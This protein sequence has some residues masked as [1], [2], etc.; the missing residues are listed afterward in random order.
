[1]YK[2]Y[3]PILIGDTAELIKKDEYG[4]PILQYGYRPEFDNDEWL[5]WRQHGKDG[6]MEFQFGGSDTA[7]ILGISPWVSRHKLWSMKKGIKPAF[8][9][10]MNRDALE[11]GHDYEEGIRLNF[12]RKMEEEGHTVELWNDTNMYRSGNP[13][14]PFAI[15]DCDG[16]VLID[17][18][19]AILECKS[20][21]FDLTDKNRKVRN[22][23]LEN[24]A[25]MKYWKKGQVPPYYLCQVRHY[26]AVLNID[27]AYVICK[28]SFGVEP[29][30]IE[31]RRDLDEEEKLME[32][33][34]D[35]AQLIYNNIEPSDEETDG[36]T[37]KRWQDIFYPIPS[38]DE[39]ALPMEVQ[40][41]A[42][43]LE[44]LD[45]KISELE[46]KIK[47]YEKRKEKVVTEITPF[48]AEHE[49]GTLD[50]L[51]EYGKPYKR[52]ILKSETPYGRDSI[53]TVK[54]A[55]ELSSTFGPDMI[56]NIIFE[57]ASVTKSKLDSALKPYINEGIC[58][59]G[60]AAEMIKKAIIPG[61]AKPGRKFSYDSYEIDA[62]GFKIS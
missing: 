22:Q 19:P 61:K 48:L 29:A 49:R 10:D 44:Y 58:T 41:S 2:T 20:T 36:S 12:C 60:D 25:L 37:V 59:K 8:K 30:I 42:E 21:K 31:V 26:M 34:Y 5:K 51:D 32:A 16:V 14:Y 54:L 46:K 56:Q 28:Y 3:N 7:A 52:F 35:F 40:S 6:D 45:D 9:E 33:E 50:A 27:T 53:D 62:D 15:A 55:E 24:H 18:S 57:A 39:I 17:G 11:D 43:E 38:K 47:E 13:K 23:Y 1:M 4:N